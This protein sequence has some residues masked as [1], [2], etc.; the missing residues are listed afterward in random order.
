MP[1]GTA[2]AW[3]RRDLRVHD[4]PA[5][6]RAVEQHTAVAPLFVTDRR[7]LDGARWASPNRAWFMVESLRVLA[8]E[9]EARGGQLAF[10]EGRPEDTVVAFARE[11]GASAVYASRDY[12]PFG[13]ARDEAVAAALARAGI[14]FHLLP[15]LLCAEPEDVLTDAG[16]P[17][18]VF[19]PFHRR[20]ET[21]TRRAPVPAPG[22]IPW[23][24][25]VE[26]GPPP[27]TPLP[28]ARERPEPGEDA[29]RARLR[30]WA[31]GP[32]LARYAAQ[33]DIPSAEGTS[34]LSQDLRWGLLSPVEVLAACEGMGAGHD[35]FRAEI[36]WREFFAHLLFHFPHL[37]HAPMQAQFA[38]V[39]WED[40]PEGL[41]AWKDG[42]T[43]YPFV[44]AAMRELSA[45]GYMHNRARMVVASFLTKDLLVHWSA[46]ER[47]FMEHL[48]DG[49]MASNN[50]GWQWAASTGADAQP[51][52]RVFNPVLQGKKF[53]PEGTYVR[54]WVP[55][56][57]GVPTAAIHEPW[58]LPPLDQELAGCIIGRDYPAP[59]VD[60]RLARERALAAFA[61]AGAGPP[62]RP[63]G[64]PAM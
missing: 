35:R 53:D 29:A 57:E 18:R 56:L 50:G 27:P 9:V 10:R 30:A 41:A 64:R 34:R 26:A 21:V 16:E 43:G 6:A 63:D 62:R 47:F 44:D 45:T 33:R 51:Y 59:I 46:G 1:E 20:W 49:D 7:L 58:T 42:R 31:E 60:H 55:E 15:G 14:A 37:R 54:R 36:A 8:R 52:F 23:P 32:R 5:L 39:R 28:T 11:A 12:T 17:Y 61:G 3:F 24:A 2:V 48:F 22:R 38:Q 40:D 13:R 4:H 25:G 19:T